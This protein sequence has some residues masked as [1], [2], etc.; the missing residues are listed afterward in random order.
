ME[1]KACALARNLLNGKIHAPELCMP[2]L[3]G[4]AQRIE[5]IDNLRVV[6]YRIFTGMRFEKL[7]QGL[8]EGVIIP[9]NLRLMGRLAHRMPP[10]LRRTIA[11]QTQLRNPL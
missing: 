10:D 6:K 2:K 3:H 8:Y 9:I 11:Q 1:S 5:K 7:R 4:V